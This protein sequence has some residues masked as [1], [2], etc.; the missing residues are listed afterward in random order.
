MSTLPVNARSSRRH[1][2]SS[3]FPSKLEENCRRWEQPPIAGMTARGAVGR[4]RHS[5]RGRRPTHTVIL[6]EAEGPPTPS[7]SPRPKAEGPPT[8]S[9]S[10][11]PKHTTP[12]IL[13]EAEGR[14]PKAGIQSCVFREAGAQWVLKLPLHHPRR[15]R[16]T[17][18]PSFSPRPKAEGGNPELRFSRSE[19]AMGAEAT[20]PSSSPKPKHTTPVI[21][22]EAEGRRRESRVAVPRSGSAM[23]LEAITA[24]AFSAGKLR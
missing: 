18:P 1:C 8:P 19:N 11:K 21:L 22:A 20:T 17:P 15:S 24:T 10:P 4:S 13:A 9:F 23:N 3:G 14:R 12:V 16:S 6:A 5:R 2:S 7:F